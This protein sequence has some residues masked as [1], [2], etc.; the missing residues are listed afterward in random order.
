MK[1]VF[2]ASVVLLASSCLGF[3]AERLPW[4]KLGL[5]L[6][7]PYGI[8]GMN[9]EVPLTRTVAPFVGLGSTD[10]ATCGVVGVRF[11]TGSPADGYRAN[12]GVM[13]GTTDVWNWSFDSNLISMDETETIYG[14][15]ISAGF[16][17]K[18]W[19]HLSLNFDLGLKLPAQRTVVRHVR[20]NGL[21]EEERTWKNENQLLVATGLVFHFGAR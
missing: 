9:A 11:Y 4:V 16:E 3:A 21:G 6:G 2:A 18:L 8:A 10:S 19:Q 7:M 14:A 20:T 17:K 5:G 15:G 12:L 1:K 13:Y